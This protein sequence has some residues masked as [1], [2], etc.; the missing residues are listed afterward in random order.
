MSKYCP[1]PPQVFAAQVI[2]EDEETPQTPDNNESH[3][4]HEIHDHESNRREE[5]EEAPEHS[6][7]PNGSQ[8]NYGNNEFPLDTFNE[9]IKVEESDGDSDI[10]YIHATQEMSPS[11][12]KDLISLADTSGVRE[13]PI[14]TEAE[15]ISTVN[16][17]VPRDLSP[18]ELLVRLPE[19]K[20]L[21]VYY[22]PKEEEDPNWVPQYVGFPTQRYWPHALDRLLS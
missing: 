3:D 5:T 2:Q 12:T 15:V 21:K 16:P 19:D 8:Y 4:A 18:Q 20:C 7:D 13:D 1:D 14:T 10:V 11:Q 9:Y 22:Q 6:V 17:V